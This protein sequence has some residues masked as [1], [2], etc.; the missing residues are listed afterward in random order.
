MGKSEN[1]E[2]DDG[3]MS[4]HAVDMSDEGQGEG[5]GVDTN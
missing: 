4:P 2:G 5:L 3:G 1:E